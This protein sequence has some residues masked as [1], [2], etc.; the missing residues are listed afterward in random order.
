MIAKKSSCPVGGKG[1]TVLFEIVDTA[2]GYC[3]KIRKEKK[4]KKTKNF[5]EK[6][7]KTNF[8]STFFCCLLMKSSIS[9][10]QHFSSSFHNFFS[11]NDN[12]KHLQNYIYF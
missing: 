6:H 1:L 10:F 3:E 7:K 4:H 11:L 8:H 12:I 9:N 5:C 2:I